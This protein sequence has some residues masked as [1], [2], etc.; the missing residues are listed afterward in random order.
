MSPSSRMIGQV[1][2]RPIIKDLDSLSSVFLSCDGN[3]LHG[4]HPYGALYLPLVELAW[5]NK[6][7]DRIGKVMPCPVL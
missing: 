6:E 5:G 2:L 7:T 1:C 4:Q 3:S